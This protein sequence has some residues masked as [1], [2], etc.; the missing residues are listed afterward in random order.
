MAHSR[1]NFALHQ[2]YLDPGQSHY[3][4][5]ALREFYLSGLRVNQDVAFPGHEE[6]VGLSRQAKENREALNIAEKLNAP[7]PAYAAAGKIS[8][9]GCSALWVR[10]PPDGQRSVCPGI[11]GLVPS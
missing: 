10:H 9:H 4:T 8:Q 7:K 6:L 3:R 11:P 2:T 5:G 1:Y